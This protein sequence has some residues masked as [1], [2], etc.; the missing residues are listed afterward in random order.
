M[1][2][3]TYFLISFICIIFLLV[4]GQSILIPFILGALFWFMMRGL[5]AQLNNIPIVKNHFPNWMTSTLS[6]LVFFI[7]LSLVFN[8]LS[9]NINTLRISLATYQ[10]NIGQLLEKVS[11]T[12]NIDA[13][14]FLKEQLGTLDFGELLSPVLNALTGIISSTFM[15]ILYAIFVL[16]EE[17]NF[18]QKLLVV[19]KEHKDYNR[20]L[21]ILEKIDHS[22]TQYFKLKTLVSLIT[23]FLSFLALYFIGVDSPVFWAFLIFLLNFI[24]TIGS[25]I[26]TAFPAMFCLLQFG[27]FW[28]CILVILIVGSIQVIVGNIIEPRVMG[29]S[30]N[31]SPLVTI[32]ALSL[33]G[34]IWGVTG[35]ILSVPITVVMIIVLSQFEKTKVWAAMLSENGQI[36]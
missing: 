36:T 24:P 32:L 15:I 34:L 27:E 11:S 25:L 1:K 5:K 2:N 16:L 28:P 20:F 8:I 9:S 31:I 13:S 10:T 33:W 4:Q 3:A 6:A 29:S 12:F 22:I 23:A 7:F 19:F 14:A 30:M 17:S 35:M 21:Q 18:Q 26:A